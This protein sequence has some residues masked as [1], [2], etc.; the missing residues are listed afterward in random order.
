MTTQQTTTPLKAGIDLYTGGV[1]FTKPL[2]AAT[3]GQLATCFTDCQMHYIDSED[4]RQA[5]RNARQAIHDE[6][7]RRRQRAVI[8]NCR[9]FAGIVRPS[10]DDVPPEAI[11]RPPVSDDPPAQQIDPPARQ[12][13]A[14]A[15]VWTQNAIYSPLHIKRVGASLSNRARGI[16][17]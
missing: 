9:D 15:G 6:R 16:E 12:S 11:M 4:N 17:A 14:M 13:I 7:L 1:T 10:T 8:R 3:A 2:R 5:W